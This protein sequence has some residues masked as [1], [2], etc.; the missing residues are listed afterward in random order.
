MSIMVP[1]F[2]FK[3]LKHINFLSVNHFLIM[4]HSAMTIK[5]IKC[6]AISVFIR[7]FLFILERTT[8]RESSISAITAKIKLGIEFVDIVAFMALQH[9]SKAKA[10]WLDIVFVF[11]I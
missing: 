3:A 5:I 4:R 2:T 10:M 1:V 6:F 8:F 7:E 9:A 11:Y